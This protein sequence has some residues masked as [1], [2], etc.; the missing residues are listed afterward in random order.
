MGQYYVLVNQTKRQIVAPLDINCGQKFLEVAESPTMGAAL[1]YLIVKSDSGGAGDGNTM[2]SL[3]GSWAGD[4]VVLVGDYDSSR[5]FDR[6]HNEYQNISE[7]LLAEL[8][9]SEIEFC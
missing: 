5:L 1:F 6:A 8:H 4:Q 3:R 9:E 2:G 7:L